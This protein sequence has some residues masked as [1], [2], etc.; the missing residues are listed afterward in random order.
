[1]KYDPAVNRAKGNSEFGKAVALLGSYQGAVE[2]V[3]W[4]AGL[5]GVEVPSLVANFLCGAAVALVAMVV[6]RVRNRRKNGGPR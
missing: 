1:V 5:A 6:R 3:Q 2:T 4:A